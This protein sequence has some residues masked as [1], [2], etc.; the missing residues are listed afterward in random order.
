MNYSP[1]RTLSM[2]RRRRGKTQK[3]WGTASKKQ[4]SSTADTA[5]NKAKSRVATKEE[6]TEVAATKEKIVVET[7]SSHSTETE[8]SAESLP[9]EPPIR[10]KKEANAAIDEAKKEVNSSSVPVKKGTEVEEKPQETKE[11]EPSKSKEVTFVETTRFNNDE[12]ERLKKVFDRAKEDLQNASFPGLLGDVFNPVRSTV[13]SPTLNVCSNVVP[14]V[15][16]KIPFA[17][18]VSATSFGLMFDV[19]KFGYGIVPHNEEVVEEEVISFVKSE[20]TLSS[21]TTLQKE[22]AMANMPEQ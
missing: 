7:V 10:Q 8:P 9:I 2:A 16:S 18:Q 11:E 14:A 4:T 12:K 17:P 22:S 19:I 1:L 13:L 5:A 15:S 21:G 3:S 20:E 6:K